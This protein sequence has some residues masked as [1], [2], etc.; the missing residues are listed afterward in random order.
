MVDGFEHEHSKKATSFLL[1]LPFVDERVKG[2]KI[3]AVQSILGDLVGGVNHCSL[4]CR[5]AKS[6]GLNRKVKYG[7]VIG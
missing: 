1:A 6:C 3:L 7:A 5:L 4:H 2:L